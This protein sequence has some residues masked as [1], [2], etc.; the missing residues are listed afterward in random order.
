VYRLQGTLLEACSCNVLC[1][2][3]IG[4]DPDTGNCLSFNAYHFDSGEINGVDVSGLSMINVCQIPGNVL[5][6]KSWKVLVLV[7]DKASDEQV[8]A[9]LDAYSGKLGGPLADLGQLVGEV[10]GVE[11]VPIEHSVRGGAGTLK[12][13]DYVNAEMSPFHSAD[14]TTTTLRDS[15]FST[16]PGSPAYV[17][18]AT[19]HRVDIPK[20]GIKWAFEGKNAIQG[21]YTISY[22]G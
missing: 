8:E 6:P 5:R 21:D 20:Y 2:C 15:I 16:I 18:K 11:R 22:S 10:L 13:G 1:P 14:G 7:D 4:E 9:M 12:A 19:H 17:S 3:W